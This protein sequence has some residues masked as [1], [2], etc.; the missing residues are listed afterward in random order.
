MIIDKTQIEYVTITNLRN[1]TIMA[2][3]DGVCQSLGIAECSKFSSP[4]FYFNRLFVNK[5]YRRQ[6][7]GTQLLLRLLLEIKKTDTMLELDINP[8]GEMNYEQLVDFYTKHG[9][10]KTQ[11][12]DNT[13]GT[14]YKF[15]FNAFIKE[16]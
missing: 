12:T 8:Y 3:I 2:K 13:L 6:G 10:I 4:V 9:F 7:I 5:K 16:S 14:Y 1:I 11:V 15:F